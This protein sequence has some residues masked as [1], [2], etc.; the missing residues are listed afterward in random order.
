M[1]QPP[2]KQPDDNS[3]VTASQLSLTSAKQRQGAVFEQLALTYLQ[4]QGL[5]LLA[6]NWLVPRVGEIDLVMLQTGQ[7]WDTLVFVEVRQRVIRGFG[8]ALNSIT[9]DKQRKLIKTAQH[10][11]RQHPQ[12][13]EH[14]CRF[15]VLAYADATSVPQWIVGAFMADAWP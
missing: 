14:D 15:D 7:A 13:S 8:N 3:I 1:S 5:Q 9:A 12:Y 10:F 4:A 2:T 11:L 6:Q